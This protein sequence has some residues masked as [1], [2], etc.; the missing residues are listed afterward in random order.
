METIKDFEKNIGRHCNKSKLR[1][2]TQPKPFKS[3]NKI[4][5]IKGVINHP[6]LD[7]PAYIFE[8][9]DSYVECRRCNTFGMSTEE[10]LRMSFHLDIAFTVI[11]DKPGMKQFKSAYQYLGRQIDMGLNIFKNNY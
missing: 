11:G 8:E 6:I 7:I 3:G 2:N 9:D 4:N 1:P 10:Y 5:T